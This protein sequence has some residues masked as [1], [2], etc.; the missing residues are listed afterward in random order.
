MDP[1]IE[2][3]RKRA[4]EYKVTRPKL[5]SACCSKRGRERTDERLSLH[6]C[7][8][9]EFFMHRVCSGMRTIGCVQMKP[10]QKSHLAPD[11]QHK[12][13]TPNSLCRSLPHSPF[14]RPRP[15]LLRAGL[16]LSVLGGQCR[17]RLGL[18]CGRGRRTDGGMHRLL[19]CCHRAPTPSFPLSLFPLSSWASLQSH[20]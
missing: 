20:R 19:P 2:Q 16:R 5:S 18:E 1:T 14:F 4:T 8:T 12:I 11:T 10:L 15:F 3:A 7:D 6:S 17:G 9:F 13:T